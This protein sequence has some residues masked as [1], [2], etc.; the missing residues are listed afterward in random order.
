MP[1]FSRHL[2]Q[3][4][5]SAWGEPHLFSHLLSPLQRGFST[6]ALIPIL[7]PKHSHTQHSGALDTKGLVRRELDTQ[8][9]CRLANVS[10]YEAR[11]EYMLN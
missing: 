6:K 5:A 9:A 8:E 10:E 4:L 2:P 7:P 3:T 1:G 11:C